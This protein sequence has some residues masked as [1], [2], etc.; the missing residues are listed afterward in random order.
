MSTGL[1]LPHDD[2]A[3][4]APDELL[5]AFELE[6]ERTLAALEA[7]LAQAET[8]IVTEAEGLPVQL[9]ARIGDLLGRLSDAKAE[10]ERRAEEFRQKL[11]AAGAVSEDEFRARLVMLE[12]EYSSR[13]RL[14]EEGLHLLAEGLRAALESTRDKPR[15][16]I[17]EVRGCLRLEVSPSRARV[18]QELRAQAARVRELEGAAGTIR[19]LEEKAAVLEGRLQES[20]AAGMEKETELQE[21]RGEAA[22][23]KALLDAERAARLKDGEEATRES[24]E[25]RLQGGRLKGRLD[26]TAAAWARAKAEVEAVEMRAEALSEELKAFEATRDE[27]L[28]AKAELEQARKALEEAVLGR[29]QAAAAL[30]ALEREREENKAHVHELA[31]RLWQA[32]ADRDKAKAQAEALQ[33]EREPLP[34]PP[35]R[36]EPSVVGEDETQKQALAKLEAENTSLRFQ[37]DVLAG[38]LKE[39]QASGR[40]L[41]EADQE[42]LSNR[43]QMEELMSQQA[44]ELNTLRLEVEQREREWVD[45]VARQ[46]SARVQEL[47]KLRAKI[48]QLKWAIEKDKTA[49]Q[50]PERP[51]PPSREEKGGAPGTALPEAQ[52]PSGGNA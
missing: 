39:A 34:P 25:F 10:G 23:L 16:L 48:Q 22:E 32:E 6:E 49:P 21:R 36:A 9:E 5:R 4:G 27:A 24:D 7:R 28:R 30:G 40:R 29:D 1:G 43:G 46:D 18:A 47:F 19:A 26:E 52:P 33:R 31:E 12:M 20:L 42:W 37:L 15:Q 44:R 41:S 45:T 2:R 50:D 11:L 8:R 14:A 38:Q 35:P 17:E 13:L 3:D 51:Q